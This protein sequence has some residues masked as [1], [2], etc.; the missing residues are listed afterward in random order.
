MRS[1]GH[2]ISI[3][4]LCR[5]FG[6]PRRSFYYKPI[7]RTPKLNEDRVRRVQEKIEAFPTYGYQ[8]L[9]LLLGMNK[10]AVQRILRLKGGR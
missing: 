7:Q 10:K 9:A 6:I 3:T 4:K 1:E 2:P 8:R 5:L